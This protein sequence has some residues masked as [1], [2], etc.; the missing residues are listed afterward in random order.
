MTEKT[1]LVSAFELL[2][3]DQPSGAVAMVDSETGEIKW[4][5]S[6]DTLKLAGASGPELATCLSKP[7][8][9]LYDVVVKQSVFKKPVCISPDA[10]MLEMVKLIVETNSHRLWVVDS[11]KRPIGVVSLTTMIGC[12]MK[13]ENN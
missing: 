10:T 5:I 11:A 4:Y 9:D 1:Q 6:A 12:I 3:D 8:E 13:T 2:A 7:I